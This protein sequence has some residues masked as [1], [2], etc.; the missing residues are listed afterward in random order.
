MG[1]E[2]RNGRSYYYRKVRDGGLV[3]SKY[4]GRMTLGQICADNDNEERRNRTAERVADLATRKAE[5]EIDR[6]LADA[7]SALAATTDAML[8]AAGYHK[9]KGQW[10]KKRHDSK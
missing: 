8:S 4:V 2:K 7:E 1:W 6:Q 9:H 5:S 3:R 10:R